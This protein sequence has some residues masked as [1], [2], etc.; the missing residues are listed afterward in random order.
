MPA[1]K[2]PKVILLI[3][4]K[5]IELSTNEYI[6]RELEKVTEAYSISSNVGSEILSHRRRRES[7]AEM[8]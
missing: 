7:E 5:R 3:I 1:K 2:K 6:I 4:G 8:R